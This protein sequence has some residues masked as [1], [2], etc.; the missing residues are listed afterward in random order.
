MKIKLEDK[1]FELEVNGYFMK[2]YYDLFQSN[3]IID[4]YKAFETGDLYQTAKLT[5]CAIKEIDVS[6]EEWLISF[7]NPYF[8]LDEYEKIKKFMMK[9]MKPTVSYNG[10]EEEK[11]TQI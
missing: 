3:V 11:K 9:D 10:S 7:K 1:E 8:L 5:Y 6:F 4:T 2:K